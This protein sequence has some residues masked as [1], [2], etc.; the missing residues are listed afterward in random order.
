MSL[1]TTAASY[2]GVVLEHAVGAT[3]SGLP[4]MVVKVRGLEFYD[5]EEKTWLPF[6]DDGNEITA[7][8][9]LFNKKGEPIFHVKDVMRVFE[10]DGAS[11]VGLNGLDLEGA[12]VQFEVAEHEYEGKTTMQVQN[13]RGYNDEPG[14][15]LKKLDAA[16]LGQ[17]NSKFTAQ[18]KKLG[19]AP[20]VASAKAP[21][22]P[23][24]APKT[25]KKTAKK[26][27]APKP[28]AAPTAD[29]AEAEAAAA[30]AEPELPVEEAVEEFKKAP[31]TPPKA[32]PKATPKAKKEVADTTTYEGSWN[33]CY[34]RKA[35]GVS[36]EILGQAFTRA[37]YTIAP[38]QTEDEIVPEDWTKIT[39]TVIAEYGVF[40]K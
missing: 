32:T 31:P 16:E 40:A 38:N 37:M 24:A 34:A 13:I 25:T 5:P 19:G 1:I 12:E 15:S 28:P 18:L 29:A 10:W 11:L 3:N 26:A 36:D 9:V 6:G 39:D 20:K 17:L 21:A 7:Y 22:A 35:A 33:E 4:Q 14:N 30:A 2:R 8:L 27:A 23:P